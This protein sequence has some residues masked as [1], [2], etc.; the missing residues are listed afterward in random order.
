[1]TTITLAAGRRI[2]LAQLDQEL[3]YE[4]LLEGVPD[5]ESNRRRIECLLRSDR[6][7]SKLTPYLIA[8]IE[9][10]VAPDDPRTMLPEVTC[11]GRF[12]SLKPA[13]DRTCD[14]SSLRIIWFQD[15]FAPPIDARV[16]EHIVALPW[17]ERAHD[18]EF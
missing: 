13:R 1:M 6:A 16:L 15:E 11:I 9:N 17:D 14:Y 8:P 12:R 5:A 18:L 10:P 2:E 3:T 4:G 7:G